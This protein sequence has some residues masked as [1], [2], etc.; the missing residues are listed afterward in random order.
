MRSSLILAAH[1]EGDL[2]WRTLESVVQTSLGLQ[3]EIVVAD[4]ASWDGC[5]AE[6]QRRFP[7]IRLVRHDERRGASPTKDLGARH[8]R[9]DVLIFLDSHVKPES[10]ALERLVEDV[11]LC[12][13]A[14]R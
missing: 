13:T 1:N 4:D 11:E 5:V 7:E 12:V 9:G 10:G 6:A 14:R 2:L 3:F 8:A